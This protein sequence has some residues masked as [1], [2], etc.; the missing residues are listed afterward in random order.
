MAFTGIDVGTSGCKV[1]TFDVHG[2]LLSKAGRSYTEKRG[3]GT[4]EID[5]DTVR[6]QVLE[7]LAEAAG[8]C[9]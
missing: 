6:A 2:N 9:P 4:R 3:N 1:C 7:A 5:P 8:K